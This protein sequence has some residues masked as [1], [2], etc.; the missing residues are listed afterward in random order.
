MDRKPQ[1][2]RLRVTLILSASLHLVGCQTDTEAPKPFPDDFY[3]PPLEVRAFC[4]GTNILNEVYMDP[5][6]IP[7][8]SC[9]DP[10]DD[11]EAWPI[12]FVP[13]PTLVLLRVRN[14]R[15]AP[16]TL[17][18]IQLETDSTA[19][20]HL[21]ELI[22]FRERQN[23]CLEWLSNPA[24]GIDPKVAWFAPRA[25]QPDETCYA[26]LGLIDPTALGTPPTTGSAVFI[27]QNS[28]ELARVPI[29]VGY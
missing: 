2:R 1:R 26:V 7:N 25:L 9:R 11:D 8:I 3:T 4:V 5:L 18:R 27:G 29:S 12:S 28:M 24:T 17:T 19:S 14:L 23:E 10:F 6:V 16:I 21:D 22:E 13:D 20:K 15:A